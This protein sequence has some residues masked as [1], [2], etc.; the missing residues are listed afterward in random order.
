MGEKKSFKYSF[1]DKKEQSR[2]YYHSRENNLHAL[3]F[4]CPILVWLKRKEEGGRG[5]Y[6]EKRDWSD[7][8]PAGRWLSE[9][10]PKLEEGAKW[11][12]RVD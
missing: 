9:T 10:V 11:R 12:M 6:E 5:Q 2:L 8:I 3:L 1:K 7:L 4:F